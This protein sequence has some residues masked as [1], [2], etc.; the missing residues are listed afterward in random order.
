MFS[1]AVIVDGAHCGAPS[2]PAEP[3]ANRHAKCSLT[4]NHKQSL[5]KQ[6]LNI[7]L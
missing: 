1:P 6:S 5:R 2:V 3:G 7:K 4:Y